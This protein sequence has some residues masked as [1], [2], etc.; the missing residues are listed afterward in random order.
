MQGALA[1]ASSTAD[2]A[3]LQTTKEQVESTLGK[4]LTDFKDSAHAK[5]SLC[6]RRQAQKA[7]LDNSMQEPAVKYCNEL[8]TIAAPI[9]G[10]AP[11]PQ[12]RAELASL[13]ADNSSKLASCQRLV[14]AFRQTHEA[15]VALQACLEREQ[16]RLNEMEKPMHQSLQLLLQ[17]IKLAAMKLQLDDPVREQRHTE[18]LLRWASLHPA[19]L[20]TSNSC[21]LC[22]L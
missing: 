16:E 13:V 7:H 20:V 6:E 14:T 17:V 3:A 22:L 19:V 10:L 21:H 8:N 12:S 9:S 18:M 4:L 2:L 15:R 5:L 11:V 1:S